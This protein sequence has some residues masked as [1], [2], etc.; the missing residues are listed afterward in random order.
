MDSGPRFAEHA[1]NFYCRE[2]SRCGGLT[3][4][5]KLH[6]MSASTTSYENNCFPPQIISHAFWLYSSF[7]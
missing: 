2:L 6:V 7:R 4:D 3:L 1:V 5:G